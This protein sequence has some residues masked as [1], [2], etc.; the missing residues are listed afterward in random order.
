M[1]AGGAHCMSNALKVHMV[2]HGPWERP[3]DGLMLACMHGQ[4]HSLKGHSF[5]ANLCY[6]SSKQVPG[7]L[8]Q[9]RL[10]S[11]N[12]DLLNRPSLPTHVRSPP[13]NKCLPKVFTLISTTTKHNWVTTFR[14]IIIIV[15]TSHSSY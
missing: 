4:I 11:A 13:L 5:H 3:S 8:R 9:S 15:N 6:G 1:I 2:A 14:Q 12:G 10:S 7:C